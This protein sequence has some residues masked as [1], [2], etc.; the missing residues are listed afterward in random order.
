MYFRGAA[1]EALT[2]LS[3]ALLLQK[4]GTPDL[5]AIFVDYEKAFDIVKHKEIMNDLRAINID[6]KY[7]RIL[8]N[9]YWS[10]LASLSIN[11]QLSD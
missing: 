4:V 9:L 5:Y 8:E 7:V 1:P 2:F 3:V 11:G 6:G 10:Q